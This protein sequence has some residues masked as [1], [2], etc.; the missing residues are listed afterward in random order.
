MPDSPPPPHPSAPVLSCRGVTKSYGDKTVLDGMAVD[1]APGEILGF[2][3]PNGAGK[4]TLIKIILGLVTPSAG[5]VSVFGIDLFAARHAA[6]QQVGAIVE[7]PLFFEYMTARD[8]LV[9]LSSLTRP[10]PAAK[11]QETLDLVGLSE[12][13]GRNVGTFSY[14]MKQRLGI[15]QA[16]LPET[17]LLILDEPTNG[18]DPHGIA[19]MRKLIRDL[20]RRLG[21]S[22]FISSHLLNEVEQVCDRVIII[23]HGKKV[24]EGGVAA[25]KAHHG[26]VEV[27]LRKP[28]DEGPIRTHPAFRRGHDADDAGM[29]VTVAVF[30]VAA[31]EV[32][33][34]V[35]ALTAAGLDILQ[36][37]PKRHTLEDLFIESTSAGDRDARIDSF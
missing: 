12:V 15:A 21:I 30:R 20:A 35:R 14:G 33:Q 9:H 3:G 32:P 23:H 37:K 25:L 17:R 29:P 28:A 7:A 1:L 19:G 22:V 6:M 2:L 11:V 27:V 10:V 4:T 13:S 24:L 18:L 16:L 8:N 36:V 31:A 34:L 26:E 5:D